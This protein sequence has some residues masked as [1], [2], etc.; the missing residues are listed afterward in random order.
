MET[1]PQNPEFRNNPT[2]IF[3]ND[4]DRNRWKAADSATLRDSRT[5]SIGY[6]IS[7]FKGSQVEISKL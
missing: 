2:K 6:A 1:Q 5:I 4:V 3:T 7:C